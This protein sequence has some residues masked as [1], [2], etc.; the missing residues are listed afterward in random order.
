M[1][2]SPVLVAILGFLPAI[3]LG[4]GL[5][6]ACS[7]GEGLAG[8]EIRDP[9]NAGDGENFH[10]DFP[11]EG[12]NPCGVDVAHCTCGFQYGKG[13]NCAVNDCEL[14][15]KVKEGP[16]ELGKILTRLTD[17]SFELTASNSETCIL[18]SGD[19]EPPYYRDIALCFG[20]IIT[21]PPTTISPTTVSP[22]TG[23]PTS[24]FAEADCPGTTQGVVILPGGI[25]GPE[26]SREFT[27]PI[28]VDGATINCEIILESKPDD[29]LE[30]ESSCLI[31]LLNEVD[32]FPVTCQ[33]LSGTGEDVCSSSVYNSSLEGAPIS[34]DTDN[35]IDNSLQVCFSTVVEESII[36]TEDIADADDYAT[37]LRYKAFLQRFEQLRDDFCNSDPE[38]CEVIEQ[39]C[40]QCIRS[41]LFE[42]GFYTSGSLR[43]GSWTGNR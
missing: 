7:E 26:E 30:V 33:P 41:P 36:L 14:C 8:I 35:L 13:E 18:K 17:P 21:S 23:S 1:A 40:R 15:L 10:V 19:V 39:K 12:N 25:P 9:F 34:F 31:D 37:E 2:H 28:E 24:V 43:F 3:A 29:V 20:P 27:F 42:V 16:C 4:E 11:V 38:N 22:T 32:E 6:N 5:V